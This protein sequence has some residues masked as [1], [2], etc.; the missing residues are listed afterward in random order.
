MEQAGKGHRGRQGSQAGLLAPRPIGTDRQGTDG[1]FEDLVAR[2]VN[3][4]SLKDGFDLSTPAG[5]LMA[6]VLASVAAYET[7]V[8]AERSAPVRKWPGPPASTWDGPPAS[9]PRSR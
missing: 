6:N 3:L 9:G 4:V 1:I 5:R 7:E 8:R 2:K